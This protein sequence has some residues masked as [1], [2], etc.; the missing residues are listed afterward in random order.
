MST[1]R[2]CLRCGADDLTEGFLAGKDGNYGQWVEGPLKRGVLGG[3]R[4]FSR[5]KWAVAAYRCPHCDHLELFASE[6]ET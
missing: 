1:D 3:A 5:D 6:R 2:K 4:L